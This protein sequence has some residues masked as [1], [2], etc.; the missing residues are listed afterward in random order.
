M[1]SHGEA[2]QQLMETTGAVR[3]RLLWLACGLL[4]CATFAMAIGQRRKMAARRRKLAAR[5]REGTPTS[6]RAV[7]STCSLR[8][9]KEF[10]EQMELL[11]R[12]GRAFQ[13][14]LQLSFADLD[15]VRSRRLEVW[16]ESDREGISWSFCSSAS[17]AS[18]TSRASGASGGSCGGSSR[19]CR[20]VSGP[21]GGKGPKHPDAAPVCAVGSCAPCASSR[22]L[23]LEKPNMLGAASP[24]WSFRSDCTD[25]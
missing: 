14:S 11:K 18:K 21:G 8:R 9:Q 17:R 10:R 20:W 3:A 13:S 5:R 15:L 24:S 6:A 7:P 2:V 4:L 1:A 25:A 22:E 16:D 12:Q 23:S 19:G